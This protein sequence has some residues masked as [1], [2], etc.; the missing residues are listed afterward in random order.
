MEHLF[1]FKFGGSCLKNK[2]SM[3][4][5]IQI[6]DHYINNGKIIIVTSAFYGV[7][8]KLIDWINYST[9]LRTESESENKLLGIKDFHKEI[10]SNMISKKDLKTESLKYLDERFKELKSKIP[11]LVHENL[12]KE[13]K[14][15]ILSYGERLSTYIYSIYLLD[16]GYKAQFFSTDDDL[17]ITN[18]FFGNALPILEKIETNIP[19]KLRSALDKNIIPIISGYYGVSEDGKITTLGR[20]GTD[21][22]AT[23]VGY[24]LSEIY[25]VKV[26]FWK[27]VYGLLSANPKF[28][29]HAKLVERVSF[30]EAK[31]LAFFGS[32]IIHPLCLNTAEIKDIKVELRNFNDPFAPK[33][34]I[35]TKQGNEHESVI[36][37]ITTIE[38]ISMITIEGEAMVSL[39]GT[40]AKVF[41]IIGEN[42]ININFISQSSSENNI[43]FGVSQK[44]GFRAGNVLANSKYFGNRWLQIKVDHEMSLVAVV[45]E[46]MQHRKGIAGKV[47]STLGDVD[48]NVVAIAQGSSELN[49]TFVIDQEDLEKAIKGL[50][51]TFIINNG[52]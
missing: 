3:E 49:I 16:N 51:H 20:G 38:K 43:T 19:L 24:A 48:V 36:K 42:D 7:T 40:A 9:D 29:C 27:D 22:S 31:E 12:N 23:I 8:D 4:N 32:K 46:G 25:D 26:I 18:K 52:H 35:I 21:F 39:P 50:Y 28:E 13:I 10:I 15:F 1:I 45:G 5:T 44:D 11:E 2:Q 17:I 34:T 14:D 33:S 30:K 41:S 6:L 47:F 37:A